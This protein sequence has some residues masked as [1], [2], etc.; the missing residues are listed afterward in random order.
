MRPRLDYPWWVDVAA[1][2]VW[3]GAYFAVYFVVGSS[4]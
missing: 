2:V 4:R 1:I 3:V